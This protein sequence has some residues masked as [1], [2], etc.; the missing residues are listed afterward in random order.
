[1]T[2]RPK[3]KG[4]AFE[5]ACA[6]WLSERLGQRIERRSLHGTKDEG[7]L[8]WIVTPHGHAG[9]VECKAGAQAEAAQPAKVAE[10]RRQT[11]AER[12]NSCAGFALLAIKTAGVGAKTLGRTR[13]DVTLADLCRLLLLE[14][15]EASESVWV[16]IDLETA[17]WCVT[18]GPDDL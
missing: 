5:T 12:E 7:D 4:T 1:M 14:P 15:S 18:E 6:R 9:I 13:C 17:C 11:L 8:G 10:W 3:A 16:T 2:N